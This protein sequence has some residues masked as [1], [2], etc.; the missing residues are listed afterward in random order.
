MTSVAQ[1]TRCQINLNSKCMFE[2]H[3]GLQPNICALTHSGPHVVRLDQLGLR[4]HIGFSILHRKHR[5][6]FNI[7]FCA[8]TQIPPTRSKHFSLACATMAESNSHFTYTKNDSEEIPRDTRMSGDQQ[9]KEVST[10]ALQDAEKAEKSPPN[11]FPEG[12]AKAW[13]TVAGASVCLFVSFGWVNCAGVF[14]DYYQTNQLKEYSA[15]AI[16]WIPALQSR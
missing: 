13:L 3:V 6:H 4:M 8:L 9:S 1:G 2:R 16:S 12:G 7:S 10:A 5:D 15:S 11:P 14:Q